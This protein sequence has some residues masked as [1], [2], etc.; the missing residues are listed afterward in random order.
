RDEHVLVKG[1]F[2]SSE[3]LKTISKDT[4]R[5]MDELIDEIKR[6]EIIL[7]WLQRKEIRNFKELGRIFEKYHERRGDF[8]AEVLEQVKQE[9][10]II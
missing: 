1:S 8:F 5:S 3:K 10:R 6:R 2:V 7:G 4:G 9:Q